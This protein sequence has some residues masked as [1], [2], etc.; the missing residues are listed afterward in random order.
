MKTYGFFTPFDELTENLKTIVRADEGFDAEAWSTGDYKIQWGAVV[1]CFAPTGLQG[2]LTEEELDYL[3]D[4][5]R[6][7]IYRFFEGWTEADYLA[8][9]EKRDAPPQWLKGRE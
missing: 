8:Y 7:T 6:H 5:N 3:E 1:K 2:K 9:C 4:C